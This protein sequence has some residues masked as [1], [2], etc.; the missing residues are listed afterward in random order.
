MA[1]KKYSCRAGG[2]TYHVRESLKSWAFRWNSN[3]SIWTRDHVSEF[4]R[5]Q[6]ENEV[7]NGDWGQVELEFEEETP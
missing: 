6:F 7:A 2:K 3:E 4:E 5:R 1:E